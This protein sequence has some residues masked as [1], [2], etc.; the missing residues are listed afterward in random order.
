M[1][2]RVDAVDN[3]AR[4]TRTGVRVERRSETL[5]VRSSASNPGR[6][7]ATGTTV[8]VGTAE[9]VA[10]G[11]A[12]SNFFVGDVE[13]GEFRS[14]EVHARLTGDTNE[15]VESPLEFEYGVDGERVTREATVRFDPSSGGRRPPREAVADRRSGCLAWRWSGWWPSSAGGT[16]GR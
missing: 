11:N 3:P 14:F 6:T 1:T 10:P 7:N 12:Q 16:T 4:I 15:T 13:V 2:A 5:I 9:H 8:T